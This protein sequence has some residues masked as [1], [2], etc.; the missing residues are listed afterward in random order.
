MSIRVYPYPL[1]GYGPPLTL[2]ERLSP[3]PRHML[4]RPGRR[5]VRNRSILLSLPLR[6]VPSSQVKV[7]DNTSLWQP[8][9]AD[10]LMSAPCPLESSR[11]QGCLNFFTYIKLS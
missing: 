5:S 4:K 1:R 2:R 11:G 6:T 9:T 7:S 8:P 10:I 3:V